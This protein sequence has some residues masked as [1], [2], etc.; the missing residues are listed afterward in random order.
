MKKS[1]DLVYFNQLFENYQN[2]FLFFATSYVRDSS[3]AEDI[4][5]DSLLYYWENRHKLEPDSNIPA[6]VLTVVKH[7]C[8]NYLQHL[9]VRDQAN[10]QMKSYSKWELEICIAT[11]QACDPE[12][13]FSK[14]IQD[15]VEKTLSALPEQTRK[16][17]IM[18]RYENKSHK[19]IAAILNITDKGVEFHITKALK[20]LRISLKDYL[21]VLLFFL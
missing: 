18:S 4:V 7:K 11:L 16:I 3:I 1:N 2:E 9:K 5:V 15:I 8:L 17:F 19:E 20:Q 14:E 10:E 6:Y 21:S 13:L 12:E